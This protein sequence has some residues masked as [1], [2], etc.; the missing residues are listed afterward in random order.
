MNRGSKE[1]WDGDDFELEREFEEV[2][3]AYHS[4]KG[5]PPRVP[6]RLERR[7]KE[8]A[9]YRIGEELRDNWI[10]GHIPQLSLAATLLFGVGVFYVVTLEQQS[11]PA[12]NKVAPQSELAA[13]APSMD[14]ATRE[15]MEEAARMTAAEYTRKSRPAAAPSIAGV[16]SLRADPLRQLVGTWH[17]ENELRLSPG[18]PIRKSATTARASMVGKILNV[19]YEWQEEG[20]PQ[21]G[22]LLISPDDA[23]KTVDGVWIDSWH[24]GTSIMNC[25]GHIE[26]GMISMLGSYPAPSGPDWGWRIEIAQPDTNSFQVRMYNITPAGQEALAVEADYA[27]D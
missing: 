14:D 15:R 17:G 24:M 10:F 13:P 7:I 8:L 1:H 25:K 9:R 4:K 26:N 6:K 22:L 12:L 5:K 2:S 19:S 18:R 21:T 11:K 20:K 27:R 23:G 16:Q 3:D